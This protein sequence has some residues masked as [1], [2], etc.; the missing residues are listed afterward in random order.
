MKKGN[1]FKRGFT[2]LLAALFVL[3]LIPAC[4][5][6]PEGPKTIYL[7]L[8]DSLAAGIQA[9]AMGN[10]IETNEGYAD[11]LFARLQAENPDL[12][13]TKLGCPGETSTSFI[14]GGVCDYGAAGTQF[15]AAYNF[16]QEN[17]GKIALITIDLGANDLL[18]CVDP[19]TQQIDLACVE[20]TFTETVPGN[21]GQ[22]LTVLQAATG[23]TAPIIGMNYYNIFLRA[24]FFMPPIG[25]QLA[26]D[27]AEL[28]DGGNMSLELSYGAFDVPVADVASAYMTDDFTTMVPFPLPPPFDMVPI[29]V[30]TLCSLTFN[31]LPP[32]AMPNIH[33][34]TEG[35]AVIAD[36]FEEVIAAMGGLNFD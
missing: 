35:Y 13:L 5:S 23:D 20:E 9:D 18:A 36:A 8:G 19:M 22:I 3:A 27:S 1:S 10:N 30:A 34:N 16:I 24:W 4:N 28:A 6:F 29:N 15:Q 32:P 17:L 26:M 21:L 14:T 12:T 2:H 25:M 33:P 7:S 31:C 11:Q